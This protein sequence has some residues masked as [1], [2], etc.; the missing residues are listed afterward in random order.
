MAAM[1]FK[2]L[3]L[4]AKIEVTEGTDPTPTGA[5]NAI[6]TRDLSIEPLVGEVLERNLDKPTFGADPGTMVGKHVK[7]TFKVEAAG[8]GAAGTAP[9]YGPLLRACGFTE[10]IN[11]A[12][13]VVY[14]TLDDG[15][16]IT[17]YVKQGKVLHEI[18]GARGMLKFTDSV[19]NYPYFEFE[20]IGRYVGPIAHGTDLTPVYTAFIQ[21]LPFRASTVETELFGD[22]IGLREI[23]INFGQSTQMY[24]HSETERFIHEDRKGSADIKFEEPEIGDHDYF[25]DIDTDT[26]G[27]LSHIHGTTAGNIIEIVAPHYQ[28]MSPKRE[29]VQ[30][31]STLAMSGPIT[32]GASGEVEIIIR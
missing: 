31:I 30:G 10:T 11:A 24:E 7:V 19:R 15:P 27:E 32:V 17:L 20:F 29:N 5:A 14:T 12:V 4:L 9:A 22:L 6:R 28:P 2:Q 3:V 13:D 23:A 16:S 21:P 18:N 8:S 26:A 1:K 25:A